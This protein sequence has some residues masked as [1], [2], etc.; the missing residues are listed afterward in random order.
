MPCVVW[1]GEA[2]LFEVSDLNGRR[3]HTGTV[4]RGVTTL[5]LSALQPGMYLAGPQGS[6]LQRLAVNG[7]T[8]SKRPALCGFFHFSW[9]GRRPVFHFDSKGSHLTDFLSSSSVKPKPNS[10]MGGLSIFVP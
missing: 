4:Y 1:G 10:G 5:D 2:A 8:S 6:E 9:P 7:R 3:V